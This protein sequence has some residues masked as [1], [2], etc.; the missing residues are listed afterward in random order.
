MLL[1]LLLGTN[2]RGK[3]IEYRALLGSLSCELVTPS[4]LGIE[5]DV[6]ES[7]QTLEEN[8]GLKAVALA[9]ESGLI[10]LADDSGLEVDALGGEPGPLSARYAGE[11]ATDEDRVRYLLKRLEGVSWEKR[12]ARFRCVIALAG[13]GKQV[14]YFSGECRGIIGF[15]PRG[16]TGFGYDPIFYLPGLNKTMAELTMAEKNRLSHRGMAALKAA[17][18]LKRLTQEQ[19]QD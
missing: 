17:G 12:Q 4:E 14:S 13:C 10:T 3:V 6:V 16:E 18:A 2:N 11:N 8:A 15:E 5:K 7:G 1:R 9:A 19:S